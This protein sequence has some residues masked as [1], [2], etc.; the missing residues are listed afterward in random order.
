MAEAPLVSPKPADLRALT[1]KTTE[2]AHHYAI[3][4]YTTAA[5]LYSEATELQTQL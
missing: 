5:D 4:D 3:K 2:A 1:L